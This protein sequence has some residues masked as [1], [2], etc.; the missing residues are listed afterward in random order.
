MLNSSILTAGAA[1]L[2]RRQ[3]CALRVVNVMRVLD[4]FPMRQQLQVLQPIVSAVKILVLNLKASGDRAIKRLPHRSMD[5]NAL[6]PTFFAS[7]N[8]QV[9]IGAYHWLYRAMRRIASPRFAMLNAKCGSNAGSQEISNGF[10]FNAICK[11]LLGSINLFCRKLFASGN[12]ADISVIANFI[13]TFKTKNRLPRFHSN[14][15]NMW[16]I[17]CRDKF[18]GVQA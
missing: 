14:A 9:K 18:V 6:V 5:S 15:L 13:Q 12:T 8:S 10:K 17:D 4:V 2:S 3:M 1:T 16:S 11:H 7:H